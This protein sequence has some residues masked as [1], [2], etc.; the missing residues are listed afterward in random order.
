MYLVQHNVKVVPVRIPEHNDLLAV[1][2]LRGVGYR[3]VCS[4]GD[5]RSPVRNRHIEARRLGLAHVAAF[6]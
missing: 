6:R 4:C 3:A 2:S 1:D 5:F